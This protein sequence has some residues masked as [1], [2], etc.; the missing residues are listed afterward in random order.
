[1]HNHATAPGHRKSGGTVAGVK[2]SDR[3]SSTD[4]KRTCG[5]EVVAVTMAAAGSPAKTRTDYTSS[6]HY[7][8]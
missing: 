2:Y 5:S 8:L 4:T 7:R 6:D 1:M 3:S